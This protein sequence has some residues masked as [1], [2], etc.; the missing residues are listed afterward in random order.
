MYLYIFIVSVLQLVTNKV[1]IEAETTT[2]TWFHE[3]LANITNSALYNKST[4]TPSKVI[5]NL[6]TKWANFK[7]QQRNIDENE[8][9]MPSGNLLT[10]QP[11]A[12]IKIENRLILMLTSVIRYL[13]W[14]ST[15]ILY[16]KDVGK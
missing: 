1:F 16:E 4:E 5:T 3:Y 13:K 6:C 9:E 8:C 12:N 7:N 14:T 11:P 15:C 10:I 2:R